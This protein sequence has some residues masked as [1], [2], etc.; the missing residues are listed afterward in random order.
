MAQKNNPF[1]KKAT[2]ATGAP[3][4]PA[5]VEKRHGLG[6]GLDGLLSSAKPSA[7]DAAV[8]PRPATAWNRRPTMRS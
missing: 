2:K 8:L 1:L 7:S 3:K 5:R 6:R 4:A